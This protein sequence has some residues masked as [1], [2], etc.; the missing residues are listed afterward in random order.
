MTKNTQKYT[1]D[2]DKILRSLY[3]PFFQNFI[4]FCISMFKVYKL[5]I[6]YITKVI[7]GSPEISDNM[8]S[9]LSLE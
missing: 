6:K 1:T 5:K 7:K 3:K 2:T 4:K 8:R 9:F